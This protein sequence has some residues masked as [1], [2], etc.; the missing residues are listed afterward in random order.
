[1]RQAAISVDDVGDTLTT[2]TSSK[3]QAIATCVSN[4]GGSL[5]RDVG[6]GAVRGLSGN[7]GFDLSGGLCV[8]WEWGIGLGVWGE[9]DVWIDNCVCDLDRVGAGGPGEGA[10]VRGRGEGCW[11]DERGREK[12]RL[13]DIRIVFDKGRDS[14]RRGG[15]AMGEKHQ[16][17]GFYNSRYSIDVANKRSQN[18]KEEQAIMDPREEDE[19]VIQEAYAGRRSCDSQ[20][21]R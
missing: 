7:S 21:S 18:I 8:W 1:M 20:V 19:Y 3:G 17:R 15:A 2:C 13:R 9:T 10:L 12:E 4:G 16:S 5:E 11:D 6:G 14:V